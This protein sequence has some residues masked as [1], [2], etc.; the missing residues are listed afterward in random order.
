MVRFA[1]SVEEPLRGVVTLF[2]VITLVAIIPALTDIEG[3]IQSWMEPSS[4]HA[5]LYFALMGAVMVLCGV[6]GYYLGKAVTWPLRLIIERDE[7]REQAKNA[8]MRTN[9]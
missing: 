7:A 1:R 9:R 4:S 8:V 3:W 5:I 6:A 2:S